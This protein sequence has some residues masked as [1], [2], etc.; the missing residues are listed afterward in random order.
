MADVDNVKETK[1]FYL[2]IPAK[3]QAFFLKGSGALD[4][5]MQNRLPTFSAP[6]AAPRTVRTA[7]VC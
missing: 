1:E 6:A 4:W 2:D 3:N 7:G 5:G